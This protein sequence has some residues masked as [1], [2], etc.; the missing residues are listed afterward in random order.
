M[1]LLEINVE[2][3]STVCNV[4]LYLSHGLRGCVRRKLEAM[5]QNVWNKHK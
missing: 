1:F 2:L 5:D 4:R 3:M